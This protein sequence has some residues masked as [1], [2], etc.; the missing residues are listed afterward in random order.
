MVGTGFAVEAGYV[1]AAA[2]VGCTVVGGW[3]FSGVA[4]MTVAAGTVT[5][6]VGTIAGSGAGLAWWGLRAGE[7]SPLSAI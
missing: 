2:A 7:A 1:V 5:G 6:G 4:A 3:A